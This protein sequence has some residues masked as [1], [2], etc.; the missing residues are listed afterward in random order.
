MIAGGQLP[1][2]LSRDK[3]LTAALLMENYIAAGLHEKMIVKDIHIIVTFVV[4]YPESLAFAPHSD[5]P[6]IK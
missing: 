1:L 3:K 4:K 2:L 6:W 5:P